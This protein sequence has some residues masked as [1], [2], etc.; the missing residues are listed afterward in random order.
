MDKS[1]VSKRIQ[2]AQKESGAEVSTGWIYFPV[3]SR[4]SEIQTS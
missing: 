3:G 1:N 2:E 4:V